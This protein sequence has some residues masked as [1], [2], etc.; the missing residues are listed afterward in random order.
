MITKQTPTTVRTPNPLRVKAKPVLSSSDS[1][2]TEE[3]TP[4][5]LQAEEIVEN[6]QSTLRRNVDHAISD[7]FMSFATDIGEALTARESENAKHQ[8]E[9]VDLKG[10]L[11]IKTQLWE[12]ALREEA[13]RPK[14]DDDLQQKYDVM[15]VQFK[16]LRNDYEAMEEYNKKHHPI[17]IELRAAEKK[18]KRAQEAEVIVSF[19]PCVLFFSFL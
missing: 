4:N 14:L 19:L 11:A 12:E 7:S 15:E 10:Q 6:L 3:E 16:A 18:R 17:Y 5:Q 9:V 2:M 13:L 8:Q 1:E